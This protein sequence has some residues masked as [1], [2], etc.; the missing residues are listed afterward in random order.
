MDPIGYG[1]YQSVELNTQIVNASPVQLVLVLTD[2]LLDE[3][4]RVRAHIEQQRFQAKGA[5]INKCIDLLTAMS[6]SLD[7]EQG[8]QPVLD[9]A[10]LYE[11]M[12]LRLN[13]AGIAMDTAMLDE[14]ESLVTILRQGWQALEARNG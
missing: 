13:E 10:R 11:Y 9:L 8:G 12:M 2:A 5:G 6:S 7:F 14:V 1:Q 4:S 3:F